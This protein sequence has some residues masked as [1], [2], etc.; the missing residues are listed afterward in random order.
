MLIKRQNYIDKISDA[1][2]YVPI[3]VLTGARQVGK[4]SLMNSINFTDDTLFLMVSN[5]TD[6]SV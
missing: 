6:I 2:K 5:F 3:V 4:T 1:F